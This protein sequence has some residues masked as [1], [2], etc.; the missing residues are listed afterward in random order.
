MKSQQWLLSLIVLFLSTLSFAQPKPEPLITGS[1]SGTVMDAELNQPIPYATIIISKDAGEVVTGGI[2]N[3]LGV[4]EI[5]KI[6]EG[7]YTLK[8]QFIGYENSQRD[9]IIDR[10]HRNNNMGTIMLSA[11]MAELDAVNIVAERTTIEQQIDRK[12]INVGKDLTTAGASAADIMNN[13]PSVNLDQQSGALTL[14]GNSNVQVM[15]DGKLSNIPADQ[16]L[17]QLPSSSIKKIELITNPSAKYNPDGMSGI[18]NIVL[19]KNVNIGFNGDVSAGVSYEKNAQFNSGL[20]LNYRNGKYNLYSNYSNN[21]SKNANYGTIFREGDNSTQYFDMLNDQKSHLLKLGLDV[22]LNDKNTLSVFTS[23]NSFNGMPGGNIDIVYADDTTR[24]LMQDFGAD[25]SNYSQQYNLD[26]KLDFEKEGHNIEFEAD[27]NTFDADEDTFFDFTGTTP[28]ADYEDFVATK[29]DR[30]TL[31]LDYVNPLSESEKLELGVQAIL[32][33]T[34]IGYSSTG[35]SFNAS[36]NLVP[37]PDTQ[38]DYSRDI[39]SAYVTYGKNYEKWSYQAGLRAEQVHVAADT[40][41][42][43]A[44]TND[45]FELYPSAY[46]T[47]NPSEKNQYQVSYSRRIDRPGVGQVNPIREW[48]SPLITQFGNVDLRPQFTNSLETN[49]TRTLEKGSITAGV[50]YRIIEDEINQAVF[51]DRFNLDRIVLTNDNFDSTTAYGF[52]L[53]SNYKPLDWWSI[54]ASFDLFNQTQTGI[55]ESL[56]PAIENPT[57]SDI[58]QTRIEVDNTVYNARV[59]NNF[60]ATKKLTLTAFAMFRGPNKGIQFENKSMFMTNIGARYSIFEG[61]G[62]ISINYNDI[63]NTM[64]A[65]FNGTNPYLI[66]GQFNWESN[67]VY[68]GFNYRFGDSKYRAK[69]RKNREDNEVEG[70]GMF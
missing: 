69:R 67:T 34:D 52:E 27:F 65:R 70:G 66:Q 22:Y 11:V 68:A 16:L 38:F 40:N 57:A 23:Q 6:P 60:T 8:I 46:V 21:I 1:V 26:Y 36:G 12:V 64:K 10:D 45:Y 3:D 63:F 56:D 25:M 20:N 44:F 24:N 35:Q 53:S 43:R 15:V 48:S 51:V 13:I 32:F 4:F 33:N 9:L 42:V 17:K 7:I 29:R 61:K 2:T 31:N 39:Y 19:H 41:A 28:L 58:T 62:T 47:F 50:F 59:I 54:N 18:I 30:T 49:Y 37:T 14:R 55:T 5:S